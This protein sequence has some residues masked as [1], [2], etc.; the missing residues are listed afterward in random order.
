MTKLELD[1]IRERA[2]LTVSRAHNRGHIVGMLQASREDV[3]AL[4][5]FLAAIE[6]KVDT[7]LAALKEAKK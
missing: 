5:A 2:K 3:T 6:T 4:L 7:I 1:R